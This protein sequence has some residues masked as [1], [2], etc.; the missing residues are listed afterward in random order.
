MAKPLTCSRFVQKKNPA[1]RKDVVFSLQY[2][3]QLVVVLEDRPPQNRS[4][5]WMKQG[6]R[7]QGSFF[8]SR[9]KQA[10]RD[11]AHDPRQVTASV[12]TRRTN[13]A[14]GR[15][16][17]PEIPNG[18]ASITQ[19]VTLATGHLHSHHNAVY[20]NNQHHR[21]LTRPPQLTPANQCHDGIYFLSHT[22]YCP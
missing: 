16:R 3:V 21:V 7:W 18:V 2:P 1:Y 13:G 9:G 15:F 5:L 19:T 6:L 12:S 10:A 17:A 20:Y 8:R 11:Q 14:R 4:G 22:C